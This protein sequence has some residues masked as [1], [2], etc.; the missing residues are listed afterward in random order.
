MNKRDEKSYELYIS[1][2]IYVGT[3]DDFKETKSKYRKMQ[4]KGYKGSQQDFFSHMSDIKLA[5]AKLQRTADDGGLLWRTRISE[6]VS[7][8]KTVDDF[9][10][11][12]RTARE[13]LQ[14]DYIRKQ[15]DE[16]RERININIDQTFTGDIARRLKRRFRSLSDD[17]LSD[18]FARNRDLNAIIYNYE[19]DDADDISLM[20]LTD[21]TAEKIQGR[22]D[23][24]K[25]DN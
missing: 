11:R 16:V 14:G 25:N 17:E 1:R 22:L 8:Y 12:R 9:T 13:V 4:Q 2:G 24:F 3:P 5:N 19:P 7:R 21:T 6:K 15:A 18:F 23:A 20:E 10:R